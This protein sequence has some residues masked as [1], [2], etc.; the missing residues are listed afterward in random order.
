MSVSPDG[1]IIPT[2]VLGAPLTLL[3]DAGDHAEQ[4]WQRDDLAVVSLSTL[5]DQDTAWTVVRDEGKDSLSLTEVSAADGTTMRTLPLPES[6]G[7]ATGVAVSP[8]G[9]IATATNIG[10]VYFFDSKASIESR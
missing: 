9:Q 8:W 10:K 2:G 5:T 4:V 7:F 1:L 3:R 6:V